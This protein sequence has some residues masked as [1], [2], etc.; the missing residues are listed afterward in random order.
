MPTPSSSAQS[1]ILLHSDQPDLEVLFELS[2]QAID[3]GAKTLLLFSAD[4]NAYELDRLNT[5]LTQV[6]VPVCGGVFPQLVFDQQNHTHGC[7]VYGLPDEATVLNIGRL[8]DPA[9]DYSHAIE[10]ALGDHALTPSVLVLVD[11][12]SARISAFLD[13]TYDVLASDPVYFGGG[14]GSLSFE[15]KPCLF[16]NQGLLEDHAQLTLLG[17]RLNLG[18]EHGW[19][20]FA[21]PFVVTEADRN[22]VIS[23]DFQPAFARYKTFVEQD[24]GRRF[25]TDNF[26]D[27]SKGYPFGMEKPGGEIIVR[28]PITA[29]GETLV[30]VG[31]VPVNSVLHLLRGQPDALIGAAARAALTLRDTSSGPALMMNCISR[32]L[33][34]EERFGEELNAVQ[35][36][37]PGRQVFGVL[38]LGEIAN[39]GNYCL[40]FY[41][42]T[43]VLA[44]S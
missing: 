30:C 14:A 6:S 39:G 27:I 13:S 37:L 9:S 15:K 4:A 42:K 24:S 1:A 17:E 2:R 11:G 29:D 34:L 12:M 10:T 20:T 35:S 16:S 33:F 36:Q 44:A 23:L 3:A 21:G 19:Q 18:V 8:S 40:E 28:D 25:D 22:R 26:F 41:N 32:V 38:S 7:I 5:W 31:E 43:L